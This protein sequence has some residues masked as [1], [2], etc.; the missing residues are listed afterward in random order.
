MADKDFVVKNGLVT[1]SNNL[2]LGT[3]IYHV[4]N[5]NM[6]IG[7]S[8][9]GATFF[10]SA[11]A[12][13]TTA[14][15]VDIRPGTTAVGGIVIGSTGRGGSVGTEYRQGYFLRRSDGWNVNK[16]S[17]WKGSDANTS[18]REYW[19]V[20][21]I[22]NEGADGHIVFTTANAENLRIVSNGQVGIGTSTPSS[23]FVSRFVNIDD[24]TSSG[25]IL[26]SN[27]PSSGKKYA[28]YSSSGGGLVFTDETASSVRMIID[29]SGRV[30]ISN[31]VP[32]HL[33][34]VNGNT[35]FAGNSTIVGATSVSNT[36]SVT[37]N[38]TFSNTVAITGATTISNAVSVT[39]NTSITGSINYTG[40]LVKSTVTQQ[41]IET[42]TRMVFQQTAAPTGFTKDT[43]YNDYAMRI[44]SGSVSYTG[45]AGHGFS[46]IF[47]SRG[48]SG[49]S[50]GTTLSTSQIPSHSHSIGKGD[51]VGPGS[52]VGFGSN[53]AYGYT[54]IG[55]TG[56]GGSH[57]HS[58]S[59]SLDMAVNY[60]D[61]IM[62]T[63]N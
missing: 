45:V 16:S 49:T 22:G 40:S 46:S 57:N 42:G 4:A 39:G 33:L 24:S 53:D 7:T 34:S 14:S 51:R 25:L 32:T 54:N 44:V 48:V 50:D 6:G 56:G 62:A 28:V 23:S 8:N 11:G 52:M 61:F 9:P 20:L 13:V 55:Y 17:M 18:S 30:G 58:F 37:G 63:A 12:N 59:T 38:A 31:S 19:E 26:S 27:Y 2:T 3:V 5:G 1:G 43:G 35:Y 47:A 15:L 29:S 41:T 10:D 60:I 36:I 21:N